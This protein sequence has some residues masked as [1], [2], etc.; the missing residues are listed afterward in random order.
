M[1]NCIFCKMI[2]AKEYV[3]E[4]KLSVALFDK[5]P[6]NKGHMLII[7]KRHFSTYF[8]ATYEE[9]QAINELAK[10]AKQLL[11]DKYSPDGYNIGINIGKDAGQTIFHLHVHMIPRYKGDVEEPKGGIRN[12]KIPLIKY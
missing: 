11:D 7:P 6:V 8:D 5:F 10:R 12:F 2:S 3:L 9:V 1:D 4:N